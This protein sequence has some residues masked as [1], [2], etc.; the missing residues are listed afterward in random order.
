MV[1]FTQKWSFV[2]FLETVEEGQEFFWKDW[3]QHVTIASVLSM[4]M[5]R[6]FIGQVEK[7]LLDYEVFLVEA[8]SE[9]FWGI[10]NDYHVMLLKKSPEILFLHTELHELLIQNGA[11]FNEPQF[12][13]YGYVPHTTIQKDGRLNVGDTATVQSVNIIDMFP[14]AEGFQRKVVKTLEMKR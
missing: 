10:N 2:S 7:L 12:E 6:D 9:G 11:V 3:P 1:K 13:G 4:D 8:E 5:T 14:N